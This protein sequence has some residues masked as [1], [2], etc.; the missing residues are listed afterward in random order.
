MGSSI[1]IVFIDDGLI[2][3]LLPFFH[4][5]KL[6]R[7]D[8]DF[9]IL[10]HACVRISYVAVAVELQAKT[11]KAIFLS[12]LSLASLISH[13]GYWGP[14]EQIYPQSCLSFCPPSALHQKSHIDNMLPLA[15][16]E[17]EQISGAIYGYL[18]IS[19]T[20][21]FRGKEIRIHEKSTWE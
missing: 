9:K 13:I 10:K 1:T 14:R 17:G 15:R 11:E 19:A 16:L 2:V 8:I 4:Y 3:E 7:S 5:E 20:L 12:H 6:L 18:F 21:I